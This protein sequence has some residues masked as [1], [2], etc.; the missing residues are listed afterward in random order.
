MSPPGSAGE[1][2][3]LL[4]ED[5]GLAALFD[6]V[7]GR[8]AADAAHDAGHLLRVA[9]WTLR[10]AG[11]EVDGRLAVAAALLH[12]VVNVK[13]SGAGRSGASERSAEVAREVLPG[14]GFSVSEVEAVAEAV[15]DHSFSRG[16]TPATTLGR[17][18]QD[19]DRLE[20]LGALGA[21]RCIAT[22]VEL[23]AAFFHPED[24]WATRRELDDARYSVDHFFA[25][26]LRLPDTMQTDAGR[27]EARRRAAFMGALLRQ[28]G[29]ELD[30]PPPPERLP[31]TERDDRDQA[32]LPPARS[33]VRAPG[34][35]SGA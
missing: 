7:Q 4:A 12:D 1:L 14:L 15:R 25:K 17:A 24:P 33:T 9:R 22:G 29:D 32:D 35:G 11:D 2:E 6:L 31:T 30:A 19:A 20:A 21:F 27:R 10:L 34:R 5:A 18:L 23:G 13:K 3:G 8:M 28:L 26:L 16:A